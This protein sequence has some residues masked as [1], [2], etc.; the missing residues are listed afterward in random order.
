MFTIIVFVAGWFIG[1]HWDEINQLVRKKLNQ[2]QKS[3]GSVNR[4]DD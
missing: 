2:S 3:S 1:R 4:L